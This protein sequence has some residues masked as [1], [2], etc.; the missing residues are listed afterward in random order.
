MGNSLRVAVAHALGGERPLSAAG[1]VAETLVV[2]CLAGLIGSVMVKS[3][4][5]M[6]PS[7]L[8]I[9]DGVWG[10]A[11]VAFTLEYLLRLWTA[12]I[13]G[14][15][16][17]FGYALSFPGLTDLAAA[18]PYW[19]WVSGLLA[20]EVAEV[21]SLFALCKLARSVP[22]LRVIVVVLRNEA[23]TLGSAILALCMLLVIASGI[24]FLIEHGAQ[25]Q[26]FDS[27]PTALW[28]GIVT[29]ASVGYG[30]I[31]PITT[32]GRIFGGVVIVCGITTIAIPVGILATGFY[33]ELRRNEFIVTWRMLADIPLFHGLEATRIAGIV[34]HVKSQFVPERQVV[35]RRGEPADAMF[36]ILSGEVEVDVQPTPVRLHRGQYFG[37]IGL[38]KDV[39]RTATVT[40]VTECQL[41][42][43]DVADFRRL[44]EQ[45]PDIKA[46]IERVAEARLQA[47]R[48]TPPSG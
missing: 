10:I 37:E 48:A 2:L 29:I 5:S 40:T 18:G 15:H 45:Y 22:A 41:L 47:L 17:R 36:I 25:P 13:A 30:D 3:V 39:E 11:A 23:R 28:W 43:L 14:G 9:A 27:I 19:L 20:P 4:P 8:A 12:S 33:Q 46:S 35:V 38:L 34:R 6:T 1:R 24:M 42:T 44:I 7:A 21:A 26:V 31:V 32:W 16:G